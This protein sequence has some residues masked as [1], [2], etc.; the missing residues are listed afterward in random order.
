[1]RPEPIT[2]QCGDKTFVVRPLTLAQI[3]KIDSVLRDASIGELDKTIGVIAIGIGRDH[4][5]VSVDDLEI[6]LSDLGPMMQRILAVG[7]M[8]LSDTVGNDQAV[9]T[10]GT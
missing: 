4:P 8:V 9:P 7:G 3:R 1:M 10:S 2:L 5:E 6:S